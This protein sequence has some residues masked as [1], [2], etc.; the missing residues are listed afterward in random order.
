V[1]NIVRQALE[2]SLKNPLESAFILSFMSAQRKA[3]AFSVAGL[4]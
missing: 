1:E 4:L 3:V 2:A